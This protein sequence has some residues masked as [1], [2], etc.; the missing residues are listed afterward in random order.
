MCAVKNINLY[1][2]LRKKLG[3]FLYQNYA[4]PVYEWSE[5]AIYP[6]KIIM[7]AILKRIVEVFNRS[8]KILVIRFDLHVKELSD[9]N[10]I[11]SS[12]NNHIKRIF[13]CEYP[14]MNAHLIWVREH[15]RASKQHYHCAMLVDGQRVNHPGKL[16]RLLED[17]WNTVSEGHFSLPENCYYL[18]RYGDNH[19]L[20]KIIYRLSYMAK[21]T[22]KKRFNPK[23]KRYGIFC[24]KNIKGSHKKEKTNNLPIKK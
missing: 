6:D 9:D 16:N 4:L 8:T 21:N 10:Q 24:L 3:Y 12:F 22:T 2:P 15:D 7:C 20:G 14:N 11:I 23:T 19:M 1:F 18:W 17:A 5:K 13:A